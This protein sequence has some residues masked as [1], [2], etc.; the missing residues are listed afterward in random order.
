ME[1]PLQPSHPPTNFDLPSPVATSGVAVG[2]ALVV[3]NVGWVLFF[4]LFLFL[5]DARMGV[6]TWEDGF[7]LLVGL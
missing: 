3:P 5:D 2:V 1:E 7:E 4:F 6:A